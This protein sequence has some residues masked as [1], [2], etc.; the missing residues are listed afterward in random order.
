MDFNPEFIKLFLT[1][2]AF[3]VLFVWLLNRT[4]KKNDEREIRYQ[5]TI[6]NLTGTLGV[7]NNIQNDVKEIKDKLK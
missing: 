6:D 2:G 7:V 3:C 5:T 1:Q 4:E